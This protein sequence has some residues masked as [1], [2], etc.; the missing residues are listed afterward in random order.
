MNF[1]KLNLLKIINEMLK[2]DHKQLWC[3][4][5][6]DRFDQFWSV[7]K[8]LM[9]VTDGSECFRSIPY[10]IYQNDQAFVQ[11]IFEPCAENGSK[12]NLG[13]LLEFSLGNSENY[14][15][16]KTRLLLVNSLLN[17]YLFGNR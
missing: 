14:K 7:N 8:K 13:E 6:N 4:I 17:W 1:D 15:S 11:K 9:E 5:Q 3:G 16:M 10:R 2:K 12:K